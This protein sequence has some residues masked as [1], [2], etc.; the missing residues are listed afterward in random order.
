MII[1][2]NRNSTRHWIR[3][4]TPY[5]IHTT[6]PLTPP[7][8][9]SADTTVTPTVHHMRPPDSTILA[10]PWAPHRL[11]TASYPKRNTHQ[12]EDTTMTVHRINLNHP[13]RYHSSLRTLSI[14]ARIVCCFRISMGILLRVWMNILQG[15]WVNRDRRR[16]RRMRRRHQGQLGRQHRV[17]QGSR[18]VIK[19][20]HGKVSWIY[21]Y[22][23]K[24][25][26]FVL[27]WIYISSW[28]ALSS[29]NQNF[30][31]ASRP[32]SPNISRWLPQKYG[33]VWFRSVVFLTPFFFSDLRTSVADVLI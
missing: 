9:H 13:H 20:T 30:V 3:S 18:R 22:K 21:H 15:H 14:W 11:L 28:Y 6:V 7:P 10:P 23:F 31:G 19:T 29:T 16:K 26:V 32:P 5:T 25:V 8:S 4:P 12:S 1:L 27:F 33:F 17:L 2:T 24:V